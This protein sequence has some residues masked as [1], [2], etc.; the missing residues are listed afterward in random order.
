M[1]L[2]TGIPSGTI[3]SLPVAL[4]LEKRID[5]KPGGLN[6]NN[7]GCS[8]EER[9]NPVNQNFF[10]P[11]VSFEILPDAAVYFYNYSISPMAAN[12]LFTELTPGNV[13]VS[14]SLASRI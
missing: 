8:P 3:Q 12:A 13:M 6:I 5:K 4:L 14:L 10:K 9:M 7:A 1:L 2:T 11:T